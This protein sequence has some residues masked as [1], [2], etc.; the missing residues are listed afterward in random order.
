MKKM[1]HYSI[2]ACVLGIWL[3]IS[4]KSFAQSY[5]L[6]MVDVH[7]CNYDQTNTELDLVSKAG[8]KLTLCVEFTNKA[9]DPITVNTEFLDS[10]IT[11][12]NIKN[13]ACNASDRPKL[14]FGNFLLPYT[15]EVTLPANTTLQKEYTMQYPIGFSW[16][17]HGCLAY[18]IVWDDIKDSSMFTIRIR[19]IKYLDVF[20]SETKPIQTIR[21]SQSPTIS[22]TD[23]EYIMSFWI[24]NKGNIAEKIHITSILSNIF[25]FQKEFTFDTRIE[26]TQ[27]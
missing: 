24:Q 4:N 25:W 3:C 26:P 13:R 2:V 22:K 16:L 27:E 15:W 19:A 7:F 21:L 20:V 11:S 14:Q 17:S 6:G 18:N 8:E 12:D 5:L 10:I 9:S 23:D 1:I